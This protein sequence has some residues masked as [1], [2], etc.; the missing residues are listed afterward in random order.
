M[1]L[2]VLVFM[3]FFVVQWW[4][5]RDYTCH[6]R[7]VMTLADQRNRVVGSAEEGSQESIVGNPSEYE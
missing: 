3:T 4:S 7:D 6:D 2:E 5:W 1:Q